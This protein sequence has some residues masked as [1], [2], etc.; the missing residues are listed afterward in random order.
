MTV[1]DRELLLDAVER[2][3]SSPGWTLVKAELEKKAAVALAGMASSKDSHDLARHTFTYM[4]LK[5]TVNVPELLKNTL[6]Q[7]LQQALNRK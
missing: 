3:L 7:Q 1:D 2:L 4:A 5:D 6:A